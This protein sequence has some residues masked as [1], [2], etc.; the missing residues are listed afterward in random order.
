MKNRF[1]NNNGITLIALVITIIVLLILAGISISILTGE[2]GILRRA[3]KTKIRTEEAKIEEEISL[4][5]TEEI[6]FSNSPDNVIQVKGDGTNDWTGGKTAL[7]DN[8]T[9]IVKIPVTSVKS[10]KLF[11]PSKRSDGI[12]IEQVGAAM[13]TGL[14]KDNKYSDVKTVII[15]NGIKTLNMACF[16]KSVSLET[17]LIPDS[18]NVICGGAFNESKKLKTV[19]LSKNIEKIYNLV[20]SECESLENITIPEKVKDIDTKAF[21]N[22]TSLSRVNIKG[23][24]ENVSQDAFSG[25]PDTLRILY[26]GNE[27]TSSEFLALFN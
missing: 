23:T 24:L 10:N 4:L 15:A 9:A 20:F 6:I 3:T 16:S 1:K 7:L 14:I 17:I 12:N 13:S 11:I 27:Y 21:E 8:R 19:V 26:Q 5:K 2:N 18:V 22:C 25:C